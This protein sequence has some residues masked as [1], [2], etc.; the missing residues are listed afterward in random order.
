MLPGIPSSAAR[1]SKTFPG[2]GSVLGPGLH[3]CSG[4]LTSC[5]LGN[6]ETR[7]DQPSRLA[8]PSMSRAPH[9][10][11]NREKPK[12]RLLALRSRKALQGILTGNGCPW[13]MR[14]WR[15]SVA[16]YPVA[17]SCRGANAASPGAMRPIPG[18]TLETEHFVALARWLMK[19]SRLFHLSTT[20]AAR[21]PSTFSQVRTR[22]SISR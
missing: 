4:I 7:S 13:P 19:S 21:S 14:R 9:R 1:K 18:P 12:R 20:R 22:T 15:R 2:R 11:L 5:V 16:S 8:S 6:I 17:Q 3:R 10:R